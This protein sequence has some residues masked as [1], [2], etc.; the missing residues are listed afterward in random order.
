MHSAKKKQHTLIACRLTRK[1]W[2]WMGVL[3]GPFFPPQRDENESRGNLM[4]LNWKNADDLR[5]LNFHIFVL[6]LLL[7]LHISWKRT[8]LMFVCSVLS[9]IVFYKNP[10]ILILQL[11]F[12][13]FSHKVSLYVTLMTDF[14]FC[15]IYYAKRQLQAAATYSILLRVEFEFLSDPNS[16]NND[17]STSFDDTFFPSAAA[18]PTIQCQLVSCVWHIALFTSPPENEIRKWV[19]KIRKI[20]MNSTTTTMIMTMFRLVVEYSSTIKALVCPWRH[21]LFP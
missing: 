16:N 17:S 6:L 3:C 9:E 15:L 2:Q 7:L 4:A 11:P 8:T 1:H 20:F 13:I 21:F 19:H 10:I 18:I 12:H 14:I 5:L